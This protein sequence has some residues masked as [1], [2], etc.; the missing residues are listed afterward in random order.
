MFLNAAY[1]G[2]KTRL[3]A[4]AMAA[5]GL[6]AS[7]NLSSGSAPR[8]PALMQPKS[9]GP[10]QMRLSRETLIHRRAMRSLNSKPDAAARFV[11]VHTILDRGR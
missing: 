9:D 10:Q 3:A 2:L 5:R 11:R 4:M 7:R 1:A 8:H 6:T